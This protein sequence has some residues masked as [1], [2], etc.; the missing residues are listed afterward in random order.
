MVLRA[1]GYVCLCFVL[2]LSLIFSQW[3]QRSPME[4]PP[5]PQRRRGSL[6]EEHRCRAESNGSVNA[7][8]TTLSS[9]HT[10]EEP[11]DDDNNDDVAHALFTESFDT[12]SACGSALAMA[13]RG[14]QI[15][16]NVNTNANTNADGS[17]SPRKV[18]GPPPEAEGGDMVLQSP[19]KKSRH[20][21]YNH[22]GSTN[23]NV[24]A[25]GTAASYHEYHLMSEKS[26]SVREENTNNTGSI[27]QEHQNHGDR[28]Y[29]EHEHSPHSP[30][31]RVVH[32]DGD[33]HGC[34]DISPIKFSPPTESSPSHDRCGRGHHHRDH[35][36][37]RQQHSGYESGLPSNDDVHVQPREGRGFHLE[38]SSP[39]N[40]RGRE[41]QQHAAE[42]SFDT[43]ATG[44][45]SCDQQNSASKRESN[46]FSVKGIA[47][48]SDHDG[49]TLGHESNKK[50]AQDSFIKEEHY[51]SDRGQHYYHGNKRPFYS[52]APPV[53]RDLPNRGPHYMGHNYYPNTTNHPPIHP[54]T[55]EF[56]SPGTGSDPG[57]TEKDPSR[58]H[59][60][61]G[62]PVFKSGKMVQSS[63]IRSERSPPYPTWP[64]QELHY[65]PYGD[66][67]NT[68]PTLP[69]PP[70]PHPPYM[71][72]S[73]TG[74]PP[75]SDHRS[76]PP[77]HARL[78]AAADNY[79]P[80]DQY[81][82]SSGLPSGHAKIMKG[83]VTVAPP[84]RDYHQGF[85]HPHHQHLP[86][87]PPPI[88]SPRPNHQH[89]PAYTG[90]DPFN[91]LRSV[92]KIFQGCSYLL[93]PTNMGVNWSGDHQVRCVI[94]GFVMQCVPLLKKYVFVLVSF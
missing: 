49:R 48:R 63:P 33:D 8:S 93:Y 50:K 88:S 90:K 91:V 31:Q 14:Q 18:H 83:T 24:P 53:S 21:R 46:D 94:F 20:G 85:H 3:P 87:P 4:A 43:S 40:D 60:G 32:V 73:W 5:S 71:G 45:N 84:P 7:S 56:R 81:Q 69:P 82:R 15:N 41:E 74:P 39:S 22:H 6:G 16:T 38:T 52:T 13:V 10:H 34:G 9:H 61:G 75:H 62:G 37:H 57:G 27:G 42:V 80:T 2:C 58:S 28:Q 68:A 30:P 23:I 77:P 70:P 19:R 78:P 76:Y 64:Q 44:N 66:P 36:Q 29:H 89:N 92:R 51:D 17:L 25:T 47:P 86:I 1:H 65:P 12:I 55:G 59:G 54:T 67:A 72:A 79:Y 35:Q 26:F 11:H